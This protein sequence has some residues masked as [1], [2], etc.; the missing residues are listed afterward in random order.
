MLRGVNVPL[1][2]LQTRLDLPQELNPLKFLLLGLLKL[3]NI[4][5][6]FSSRTLFFPS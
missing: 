2:F 3:T 4:P 5:T 6:P 1:V